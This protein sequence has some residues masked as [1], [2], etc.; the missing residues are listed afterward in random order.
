LGEIIAARQLGPLLAPPAFQIGN[1][2]PAQFLSGAL[3][4]D[5]TLDL[6]QGVDSGIWTSRVCE[7]FRRSG[8]DRSP[9]KVSDYEESA[10]SN[11]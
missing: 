2:G 9:E 10:V 3:A 5:G 6:E 7:R 8:D 4:I 11:L 1:Q